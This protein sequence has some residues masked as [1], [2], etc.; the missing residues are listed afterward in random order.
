MLVFVALCTVVAAVAHYAI[1]KPAERWL[2]A[3]GPGRRA[4]R[5][6][7]PPPAAGDRPPPAQAPPVDRSPAAG[8]RPPGNAWTGP[9]HRRTRVSLTP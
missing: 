6:G 8:D 1:E 3:R 2:R 5:D 4:T 7:A 9:R